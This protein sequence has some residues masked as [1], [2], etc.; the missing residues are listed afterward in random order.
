MSTEF[1]WWNRDADLGKY[2]VRASFHGGNLAWRRK[3]GHH[4]SWEP[5]APSSDDWEKLLETAAK[6]VPRRLI[7]PRQFAEIEQLRD[8]AR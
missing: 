8:R 4:S 5:H 2:E 6:R 7:S 3:Q 1:G